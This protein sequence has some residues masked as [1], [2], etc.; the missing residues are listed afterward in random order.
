MSKTII[1][2]LFMASGLLYSTFAFD[3][4]SAK[5]LRWLTDNGWI[6]I[7]KS[8]EIKNS[9]LLGPKS[10]IIFYSGILIIIGLFILFSKNV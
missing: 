10:T 1:G 3:S 4:F 9:Q 5:A 7:P 2:L 8:Q 6:K